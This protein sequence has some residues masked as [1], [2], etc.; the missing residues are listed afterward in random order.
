MFQ[1]FGLISDI[2]GAWLLFKFGLPRI[3]RSGGAQ[4]LELS[5]ID[6][7]AKAQEKTYDRLGNF[8]I[9]LLIFGFALQLIPNLVGLANYF[10]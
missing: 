2:T 1:T 9:L 5:G 7:Q 10:G 6:E 3:V 8:G 4:F